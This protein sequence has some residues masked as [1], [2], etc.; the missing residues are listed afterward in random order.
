MEEDTKSF[1]D[2]IQI[3]KRSKKS[4]LLTALGIFTL[5]VLIAFKLP[6]VY[7]STAT[8]LI[9]RQEIP[10]E[11]VR[12][13]ITSF[14]DQR[15]QV[16]SQR[17]MTS[18]NIKAIIDK[19]N[20]YANDKKTNSLETLFE[21]FRKDVQL[22][23]VSAN[24]V[25]PRSGQP[26]QATIAFTLAFSSVSPQLAQ[27]VA[28]E[29]VSLY[30][31]EN[32]KRRNIAATEA[33]DF[34]ALEADKLRNQITELETELA[35]FKEAH[36]DALPELQ[37]LNMQLMDR[38]E[39]EAN[40]I[41]R[42]INTLNERKLYLE[43]ELAQIQPTMSTFSATGERIFG[44]SDR[45]KTLQAEYIAL[46]ARYA[47]NHPDVVK[48]QKEIKALEQ[49]VG[50]VD[51]IEISH[52]ITQKR[53]ELAALSERYSPEHPDII[54]LEKAIASLERALDQPE[55]NMPKQDL[56]V[57]P[58]NP[59]YIQLQTQLQSAKADLSAMRVSKSSLRAKLTGLEK[60]IRSA[61]Q[62]ERQYHKLTRDYENATIK[63][64]EVK[65]KQMEADMSQTMEK[66]SK[67][68]H[69]SLIEPPLFPEKRFK[70]NRTAIV[71]L[72]F[73]L[74]LGAALGLALIKAGLDPGI[75]GSKAL[76]AITGNPPLMVIPFIENT[77]DLLRQSRVKKQIWFGGI[78]TILAG[79][80]LLHFL[81][82]P[83]DVLW[84]T[85]LRKLGYSGLSL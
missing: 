56:T 13:T 73:V 19:F 59:A 16:I 68:E 46:S 33:T 17:V 4:M 1:Q 80:L 39:Q 54:E 5:A 57:K 70:P 74:A 75:Y 72:G 32:L 27:Q 9:E 65:A 38:T 61:P 45:L 81:I 18:E 14:A 55:T 26:T 48:M 12:S 35:K 2:Y 62:V 29:L 23:M 21:Q 7:K 83:L 10:Q 67:G 30:L 79:A 69:F 15:I 34:L 84:F 82:V 77:Q 3:L 36:N 37:Q 22:E 66:D 51:R 42:Q 20:L 41:D 8:I 64:R 25:D 71:F 31:N 49:E 24:V 43:A 76:Q 63:Y 53:G 58:D 78:V 44:A 85:L 50:G 28:N 52:Q 47:H 60:S 6:S 11:L 40:E